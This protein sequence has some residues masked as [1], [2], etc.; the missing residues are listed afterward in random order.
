MPKIKLITKT[1]FAE[2]YWRPRDGFS[3]A[4]K[5]TLAP[6]VV[7]EVSKAA[8]SM[9]VGFMMKDK[10]TSLVA[11]HGVPPGPNLMVSPDGKWQV[12]YIP[13]IYRGYPFTLMEGKDG[14]QILCIDEESGFINDTEGER[15]F[16]ENG[17][18]SEA[19]T[20]VLTFLQRVHESRLMTERI[21]DLL[22][23]H[24]LVEPWK[25]VIETP[26]GEKKIQ[27]LFRISEKKLNQ[28][29][30]ENFL[31]L[32]KAGA[33]PLIYCQLVS[34]QH[35]VSLIKMAG[36][37]ASQAASNVEEQPDIDKMFGDDNDIFRFDM[38]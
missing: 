13:A 31:T 10:K 3:H 15:F 8:V 26:D 36:I 30:D 5:Y 23:Q 37:R 11:I 7:R 1:E 28:L 2:K 14:K 17:E 20:K 6:I 35:M 12:G 25:I 24:E 21:C 22:Q 16:D 32:R 4:M 19:M 29:E 18:P 9:P 34:M 33:L 27:G 38:I